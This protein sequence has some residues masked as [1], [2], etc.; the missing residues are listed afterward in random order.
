MSD[1]IPDFMEP[2]AP[3]E[4]RLDRL[5][6][7]AAE[8]RDIEL[9]LEDIEARATELKMKVHVLTRSELPELFAAAQVTRIDLAPKGN[10][11]A[12]EAK[13]GTEYRSGIPAS[14]EP[15][16]REKGFTWLIAHDG[17]DLIKTVVT[18]EYE[19]GDVEK[20]MDLRTLL[21]DKYDIP[22]EDIAVDMTVHHATLTSHLRELIDTNDGKVPEG[23]DAIGG[24][25]GPVVKV[26]KVKDKSKGRKQA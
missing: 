8:L 7:K 16:R 15:D 11:P 2:V 14:W 13:L 21:V 24:Y 6:T 3:T 19:K 23:I 10:I 20:A 12:Y 25:V 18:I 1:E 4:D 17:A 5:R 9:E 26:S 22:A